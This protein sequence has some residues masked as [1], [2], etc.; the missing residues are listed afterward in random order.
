MSKPEDITNVAE[1]ISTGETKASYA[2]I[3]LEQMEEIMSTPKRM[4]KSS[5]TAREM[6]HDDRNKKYDKTKSAK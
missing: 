3:E 1:Y 4:I 2:D 5:G 6:F